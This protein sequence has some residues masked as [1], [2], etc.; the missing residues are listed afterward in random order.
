MTGHFTLRDMRTQLESL[1]QMGP[2]SKIL[3]FFPTMGG[4][5]IDQK[6]LEETQA[7]LRRFRA[8]MDS[9]TGEE[10]DNPQILKAERVHRVARG[11][12]QKPTEVRALLKQY[13]TTKKA[14]HG[15]ASN[16]RLRRQMEKQFGLTG[17][18]PAE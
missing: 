1:G 18:T 6:S 14:A 9:M 4:P 10:L 7:R 8:I 3:S 11:S 12:G 15:I 16:R 2:M 17:E 13:E 5:K